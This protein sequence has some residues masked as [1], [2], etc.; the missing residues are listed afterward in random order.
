MET[1][2]NNIIGPISGRNRYPV[3]GGE[4]VGIR[5]C[6]FL[7][8]YFSDKGEYTRPPW[9]VVNWPWKNWPKQKG[10]APVPQK[11]PSALTESLLVFDPGRIM[12]KIGFAALRLWCSYLVEYFSN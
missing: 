1:G 5:I 2:R 10:T 4:I 6:F 7:F 8:F 11:R 12:G 3:G 9:P